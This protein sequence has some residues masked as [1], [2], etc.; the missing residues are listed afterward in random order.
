[1]ARLGWLGQRAN[2]VWCFA[3]TRNQAS[4]DLHS[5]YGFVEV[6]RDFSVEGVTFDGGNGTGILFRCIRQ[7]KD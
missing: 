5:K 6:T 4:I 1:L 2:E 3:N 7:A